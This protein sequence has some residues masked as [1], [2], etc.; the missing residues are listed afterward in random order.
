MQEQNQ[1]ELERL[2]QLRKRI[3]KWHK[4]TH[5]LY[6][7]PISLYIITIT[8]EASQELK[9]ALFYCSILIFPMVTL[10]LMDRIATNYTKKNKSKVLNVLLKER[11]PNL[12]CINQFDN[13]AIA[14]YPLYPFF[15]ELG[16]KIQIE[17]S[18]HYETKS[19]TLDFA[20][21]TNIFEQD[22]PNIRTISF[23]FNFTDLQLPATKI[24]SKQRVNSPSDIDAMRGALY[25]IRFH[26][27]SQ[28]IEQHCLVYGATLQEA[29]QYKIVVQIEHLIVFLIEEWSE[30]FHL[31]LEDKKMLLTIKSPPDLM[32]LP[33][34]HAIDEAM[35]DQLTEDL[36]RCV[37][38]ADV[39]L[40]IVEEIQ[41]EK[42]NRDFISEKA[43]LTEEKKSGDD[44]Y[45]HLVDY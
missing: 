28:Y 34:Q 21:A 13:A 32:D 6:I 42:L 40:A 9:V 24:V 17:H 2:E 3:H 44:F 36:E 33:L 18:F 12:S 45:D 37:E 4:A 27:V 7:L 22:T 31:V 1:Q 29:V 11:F 16:G 35:T 38:V 20:T 5:I 8:L 19:Y 26:E 10:Y 15:R 41:N 43:R 23:L 30:E 25:K 14:S 39:L